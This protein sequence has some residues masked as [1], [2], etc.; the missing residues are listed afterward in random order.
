MNYIRLLTT[1][2]LGSL[3]VLS[4]P[5]LSA[6]LARYGA[7]QEP[8]SFFVNTTA[9]IDPELTHCDPEEPCP[10]GSAII[11]GQNANG[12]VRACYDPEEVAWGLPCPEG[13]SPLSIADPGYDAEAGKWVFEMR[14][15]L[16]SHD[17]VT[18]TLTIDFT[19]DVRDWQGPQ[20]NRIVVNAPRNQ[21]FALTVGTDNNVLKGFEIRGNY[22]V[23]AIE[24][25]VGASGNQLGPG[26]IVAGLEHGYGI[27]IRDGETSNNRIVG[28]WCGITG[29]GT[30]VLAV[31]QDCIAIQKGAHDNV[32]GGEVP[33]LGNVI[34]SSGG[35]GVSLDNVDGYGTRDNL[36][37]GNW[38]GLDA[39]G[40]QA[41][42]N[43][44][45]VVVDNES[46]GNHITGNVISGNRQDGIKVEGSSFNTVVAD[47]V[48]GLDAKLDGPVPNLGH[49]IRFGG[50]A[51]QSVVT[52]N[53][54]SH[55]REGGI[56]VR[57]ANTRGIKITQ[58]SITANGGSA[59][60]VLDGAN[61][62]LE[63]PRLDALGGNELIGRACGG[64]TVEVYSDPAGQ[65]KTYEGTAPTD[66][67]F[68]TFRFTA[69]SGFE[70][71]SVT[72]I[73]LDDNGNT[74]GISEAKY[75]PGY[76]TPTPPEPT[77]SPTASPQ[78]RHQVLLPWLG[79]G[80]Q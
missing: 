23:A 46:H 65:A 10:L 60:E 66:V 52:T 70:N 79:R 64:C 28:S 24:L 42:G 62:R 5:V 14:P 78:D 44:F 35:A 50:W 57:G 21:N 53:L 68:G 48:I 51:K 34:S 26:L 54:V 41:A 43:E 1:P 4:P 39:S 71:G 58:N 80:A 8:E 56:I 31:E 13:A 9:S 17:L 33:N 25:R 19:V 27:R 55:N 18:G 11:R 6:S 12:E 2:I 22:N 37:V 75:L 32:V 59:L 30:E 7:A 3:L 49:G 67:A 63:P 45:G 29:D 16:I 61:S 38:I 15:D 76:P 47:N 40:V 20:D 74:S 73:A 72:A 69:D 77:P 36:V